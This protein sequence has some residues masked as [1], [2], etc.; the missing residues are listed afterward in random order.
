MICDSEKGGHHRSSKFAV[1][2]ACAIPYGRRGMV[3]SASTDACNVFFS[4]DISR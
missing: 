4:H 1:S 2:L 3:A